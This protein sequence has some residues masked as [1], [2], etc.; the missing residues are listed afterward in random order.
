MS[1]EASPHR[2]IGDAAP[3]P[4]YYAEIGGDE[5]LRRVL[6]AFYERAFADPV[7][8]PLF[9]RHDKATLKGKQFGFMRLRFTGERG[10]YMGQRPRNAHHWMVIS[11]QDF[12]RREALMAETLRT[13][14]LS[15]EQ[16]QKWIAVEEAFRR[17]IVKDR[18]WPLLYNGFPTYW[19]EGRR[20][21]L[22]S[23]PTLCDAC[24]AEIPCGSAMALV[25]EQ[26][27]CLAC[28]PPDP[29]PA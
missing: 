26:V 21:Q 4:A 28:S 13:E 15:P 2:R 14:G 1:Q 29:E 20:E 12:D 24:T 18:P 9:G 7:L 19:V 8:A 6:D 25:G 27:L 10:G 17:Q 22:A 11:D 23:L 16:I 3:D 5:T